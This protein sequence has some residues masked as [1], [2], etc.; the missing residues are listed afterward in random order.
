MS[1]IPLPLHSLLGG[2]VRIG[3]VLGVESGKRDIMEGFTGRVGSL[4][5]C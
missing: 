1:C 3:V 5:S 2:G 4:A